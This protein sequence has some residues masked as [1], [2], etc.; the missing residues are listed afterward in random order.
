MTLTIELTREQEQRLRDLAT[1]THQPV[2]TYLQNLIAQQLAQPL[3]GAEMVE[4]WQ[5]EGLLGSYGDPA[6]DSLEL[7][8]QIRDTVWRSAAEA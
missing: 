5:R 7:A 1:A 2:E 3:T 6:V 4:Y 8:R